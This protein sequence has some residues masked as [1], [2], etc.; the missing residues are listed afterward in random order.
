MEKSPFNYQE[1]SAVYVPLDLPDPADKGFMPAALQLLGE[2]ILQ[3]D[4]PT[5]ILFTAKKQLQQASEYLRPLLAA[6]G[7]NLLVQGEDG[8]YQTI[9]QRFINEPKSVLIR[10]R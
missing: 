6:S 5:L 4:T 9:V 1:N 2:V 3:A 8:E 10:V 7:F